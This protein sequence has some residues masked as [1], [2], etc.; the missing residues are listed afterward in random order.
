MQRPLE[1]TSES[2]TLGKV[3]IYSSF[4]LNTLDASQ[5]YG[6]PYQRI[7]EEL[8]RRG[9]IGG[10]EDMSLDICYELMEQ[11]RRELAHK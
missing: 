8:G 1:V 7:F 9:T 6:I 11:G 5:K 10:Q 3:G 2:C 4:Y